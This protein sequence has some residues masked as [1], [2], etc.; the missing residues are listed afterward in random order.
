MIELIIGTYGVACW[1][2]FKKFKLLPV[3]TYTVCTAILGGIVLFMGIMILLSMCHPVSHDGRFYTAVTQIVPQVRG[4]VIEVPVT[5]NQP[6]KEGDEL[7]RIDPLPYE[8]EVDRLE[9]VLEGMNTQVSQLSERLAAAE[10]ARRSAEADLLVTESEYDRQARISLKQSQDKI[11]QIQSQLKFAQTNLDRNRELLPTR[12]ISE[13][14]FEASE[15]QVATLTAELDQA[16]SGEQAAKEK[17]AS[18]G[19][20]LQAAREALTGAQAAEREARLALEAESDGMNPEVRQALAQLELK[21][22]ELAE[23]VIRAPSDGY[24]TYVG[25]RPGQM[26]TPLPLTSPMVFV[27]KESP[28]FIATFPQNVIPLIEPGLEAELAFK[29]YPGRI[30][31]AKVKQVL[32]IIPE[33]QFVASGQ[34]QSVTSGQAPGHI[35]VEFEYGEDVAELNMPVGSQA[36]VAI[37]THHFH[38]MSLVR[39]IILRIKSWENYVFFLSNFNVGH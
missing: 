39:R 32:P 3:T 13:R 1:L 4:T 20:R 2:V 36:S 5:P 18:G 11:K 21:R 7:F 30:F 8:L 17:I 35:P 14:D 24:V 15:T 27:P 28:G 26:A 37:Y 34:L 10:A 22:W 19:N 12:A 23:T 9:A 29:S 38:A 16:I 6:L 33:G 25:L 31:K